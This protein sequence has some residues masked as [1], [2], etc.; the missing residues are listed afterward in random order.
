MLIKEI[1][2]ALD[3]VTIIPAPQS[4]VRHRTD[5]KVTYDNGNLPIFTAPMDA[6]VGACNMKIFEKNNIIPI[7]PR[8]ESIETRLEWYKKGYWIAVGLTEF[9]DYWLHVT[10][11]PLP[12]DD[13]TVK[14]LI[15]QANGH[16]DILPEYIKKAKKNAE[17]YK[18]NLEIMIGN[19]AEPWT[20]KILAEAGADYVRIGIGGGNCCF[21]DGTKVKMADGTEKN[22]ED[23]NINEKVLTHK[24]EQLVTNVIRFKTKKDLIKINN[25][26]TC[27][28]DHKFY[29]I[30][31]ADKEL[32]TDENIYQYAYWCD[33]NKLDKN[34]HLLI[35]RQ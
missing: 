17:K 11:F 25:N 8:T 15:D 7:M 30:N 3:D 5:I 19:I 20:Y 29:V 13:I 9:E 31:K 10:N 35:S 16:M 18:V 33:A 34:K 26:I 1:L 27:T 2:Y 22:I 28:N 24:G 4:S 6:V 12:D 32:I 14:V 23:I 21:V